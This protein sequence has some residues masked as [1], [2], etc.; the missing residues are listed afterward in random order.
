MELLGQSSI[1]PTMDTYAHVMPAMMR[2]LAYKMREII[3]VA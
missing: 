2:D 3:G 1:T